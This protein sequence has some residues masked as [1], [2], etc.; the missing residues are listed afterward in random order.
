MGLPSA[1]SEYLWHTDVQGSASG[2][3]PSWSQRKEGP[4]EEATHFY[5]DKAKAQGIVD[6]RTGSVTALHRVGSA[7][8]LDDPS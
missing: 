1:T 7:L 5:R 2:P 8:N 3:D 4:S 6:G